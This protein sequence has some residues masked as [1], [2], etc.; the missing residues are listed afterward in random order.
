M[1]HTGVYNLLSRVYLL[2]LSARTLPKLNI[3]VRIRVR[4]KIRVKDRDIAIM[5]FSVRV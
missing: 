5:G 2:Q 4:F 1:M 3:R